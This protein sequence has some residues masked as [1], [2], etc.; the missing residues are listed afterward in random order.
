VRAEEHDLF[1]VGPALD[2]ADRIGAR[3]VIELAGAE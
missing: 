1:G 3:R 2:L